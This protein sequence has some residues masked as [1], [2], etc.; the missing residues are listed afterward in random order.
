MII[1]SRCVPAGGGFVWAVDKAAILSG[2][3]AKERDCR[4]WWGG[5]G[6]CTFWREN[7]R[8]TDLTFERLQALEGGKGLQILSGWG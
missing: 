8:F 1:L 3:E 6:N 7:V 2:R 4:L 5:G